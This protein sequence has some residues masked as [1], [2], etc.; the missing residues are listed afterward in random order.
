MYMLQ[1]T[2][3]Q[4]G[5][6]LS[7]CELLYTDLVVVEPFCNTVVSLVGIRVVSN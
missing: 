2:D 5:P 3:R 1:L 7:V 6:C 4:T